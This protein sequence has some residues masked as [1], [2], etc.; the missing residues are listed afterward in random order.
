MKKL[1][2]I[3]FCLG[4]ILIPNQVKAAN[5]NFGS[6]YCD[7]KERQDDGTFKMTCHILAT[8]D[9]E[10]NH[11]EGTLILKN[12]TLESIKTSS[13]WVSQNG[14]SSNVSFK[15]STTHSGS[16]SVADLVFTGNLSDKE[17]EASFRPTVADKETEKHV[18]AIIDDEYYGKDGNVVNK[19]KYYEDCCDYVCTTVDNKYYFNSKGKSVSKEEFMKDCSTTETVEEIKT[20]TVVKDEKPKV[21]VKEDKPESKNIVNPKTGIDYGYIILP[22]GIISIIAIIKFTKKNSK[23]YKI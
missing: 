10:V 23:I 22:I 5:Y 8:T 11:I 18:C 20:E 16:F 9:Y 4:G 21:V 15:S 14:L 13:D 12:V 2:V 6:Y 19:E 1:F 3:L 7:S 17:C